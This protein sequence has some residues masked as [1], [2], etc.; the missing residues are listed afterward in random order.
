MSVWAQTGTCVLILCSGLLETFALFSLSSKS[1]IPVL[2]GG[3]IWSTFICGNIKSRLE[4]QVSE[5]LI[6]PFHLRFNEYMNPNL[7]VVLWDGKRFAERLFCNT[8]TEK[9]R[10]GPNGQILLLFSHLFL[11][12]YFQVAVKELSKKEGDCWERK[13]QFGKKS[14]GKVGA[15]LHLHMN[16]SVNLAADG[17]GGLTK[18]QCW[19]HLYISALWSVKAGK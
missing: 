9:T 15:R 16:G 12:F 13:H 2:K 4:F 8:V 11:Y 3:Q 19:T 14:W 1:V 6:F 7:F 17:G 10:W 18:P 5:N